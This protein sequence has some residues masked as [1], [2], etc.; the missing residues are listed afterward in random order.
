M[1][2][3][4]VMH[5]PGT[6]TRIYMATYILTYAC[7]FTVDFLLIIISYIYFI[8]Y[9]EATYKRPYGPSKMHMTDI[10]V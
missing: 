7:V 6:Y 10:F 2:L 1:K 4:F 3:V 9:T 8:F 5:M